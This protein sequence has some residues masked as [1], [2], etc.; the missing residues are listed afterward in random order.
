MSRIA[1][2][3]NICPHYR[4]R[5]YEILARCFDVDYF[6]FS[7]GDDW[8]WLQNHGARAGAFPFQYLKGFRVAG[9]RVTPSLPLKLWQGRYDVY[10]KCINGRFALP[11]TYLVARLSRRPFVLWTGVWMRIDTPIHRL[12]Y[13]ITRHIYRHSD[14][15]VVYGKHVKGFLEAQGV[16]T[17][18]IF[19]APH[20]IDNAAYNRSVSA[21]ERDELRS[22]LRIDPEA[23]VILFVG[24]LEEAKGLSFLLE[25]FASI[26]DRNAVLVIVGTG[27]HLTRLQEQ[28][29]ELGIADRAKFPG[30]VDPENTVV[31]YALSWVFVLPSITT[32][33]F[34]EPWGLVVN[35]AF[36]QRVPVIASDAVGAAAGGLVKDGVNGFIVPE[37]NL[38]A[39]TLALQKVVDDVNLRDS[40]ADAAG[41]TVNEWTND[42][43]VAGFKQA[44]DSVLTSPSTSG[45]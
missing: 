20:A 12:F 32:R 21:S 8:Y 34:K 35:E 40:M 9:T 18:R 2:V 37:Q 10:V 44:I 33:V 26:G 3:T 17:Q 11:I 16:P 7:A 29:Q 4:I 6:F 5:T 31:Y 25:A 30:Y 36:N 14:A 15:V 19:V 1:F 43:M 45:G 28:A 13:P 24:R 41:R 42:R 27:S 22:S 39:L 23:K 38:S